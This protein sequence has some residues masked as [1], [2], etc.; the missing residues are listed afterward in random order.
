[1]A[2]NCLTVHQLHKVLYRLFGVGIQ[3]ENYLLPPL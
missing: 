3:D 1:M 2:K